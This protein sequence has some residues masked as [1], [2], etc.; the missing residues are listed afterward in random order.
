[1]KGFARKHKV[2]LLFSCPR[3]THSYSAS[4]EP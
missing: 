1:M 4:A 2:V 3:L